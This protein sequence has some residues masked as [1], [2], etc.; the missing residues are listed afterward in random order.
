MDASRQFTFAAIVDMSLFLF[1]VAYVHYLGLGHQVH[2]S[3]I[4]LSLLSV[5]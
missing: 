3:A 2:H 5:A 1:A 4:D